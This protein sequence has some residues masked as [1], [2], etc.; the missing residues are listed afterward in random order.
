MPE[1]ARLK[2]VSLFR[3]FNSDER[4]SIATRKQASYSDDPFLR[5]VSY[6]KHKIPVPDNKVTG[7]YYMAPMFFGPESLFN[8]RVM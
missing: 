3:L 1:Y 2:S 6:E 5:V 4:H 7:K 8:R